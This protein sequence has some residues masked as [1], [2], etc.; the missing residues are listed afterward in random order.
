M[1]TAKR[2]DIEI[3]GDDLVPLGKVKD[4][5]PYVAKIRAAGADSVLTGN[6][7][8]DLSLLVKAGHETGLAVT[9][10]TTF[11]GLPGTWVAAGA[12]G[13][14]RV[15]T[16]DPWTINAAD[17]G[18]EKTLL[19]YK[20]K[21]AAVSNMD[22]LPTF[23]VVELLANA[24]NKAGTTDPV[25]VAYALQGMNY[26]GPSGESWIRAEDHQLIAPVYILSLAKAG[27]PGV[28]HDVDGSGFGWKTEA[29]IEAKDTVP[30]MKCQMERPP[31]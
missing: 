3:V 21:Y 26:T 28:R 10:Y 14:D 13:A 25:R 27:Q 19:Q 23:R 22:Y 5:S 9:Y 16:L 12:A 17:S 18:W 11:G 24:I 31:M 15:V 1:L 20:A 8:Y 2:P 4:F 30:P 29:L 6:W 7:G